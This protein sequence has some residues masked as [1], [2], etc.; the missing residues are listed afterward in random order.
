MFT[1]NFK[2]LHMDLTPALRT[3]GE[4]KIAML[5]KFVTDAPENVFVEIEIEKTTAHHQKGEVY[6][7]VII[8]RTSSGTYRAE[9]L[10]EDMY[11]AIDVAK[12]ELA[13]ELSRTKD[14]EQQKMKRGG[15][16]GKALLK[17]LG[18]GG[19]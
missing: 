2:G 16:F 18:I 14:K 6:R 10:E 4:E 1:I 12:D 19:E 11:A 3:Y 17:R 8:M 13:N 7:A 5:E 15:R 9:A